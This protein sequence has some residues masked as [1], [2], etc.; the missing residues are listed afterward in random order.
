MSMALDHL[1][2]VNTEYGNMYCN[3]PDAHQWEVPT[4]SYARAA[5]RL[6]SPNRSKA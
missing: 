1:M 4:V 3:E 6:A 2:Q 5:G